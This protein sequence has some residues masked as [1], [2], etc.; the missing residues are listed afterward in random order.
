MILAGAQ[1]LRRRESYGDITRGQDAA[2]DANARRDL[3]AVEMDTK[4]R[5]L[6]LMSHS[7]YRGVR[8]G[9]DRRAERRPLELDVLQTLADR[10]DGGLAGGELKSRL[11]RCYLRCTRGRRVPEGGRNE[12]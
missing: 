8:L 6:E 5:Q 11:R 12:V 4:R 10:R 2:I 9:I 3:L 1:S 7:Y